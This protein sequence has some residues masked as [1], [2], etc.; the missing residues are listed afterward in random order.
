MFLDLVNPAFGLVFWQTVTFLTILFILSKFAWKPIM[1]GL[2]EREQNIEDA[3]STAKKAREEMAEMKSENEKLLAQ[4]RVERDKMLKEAQVASNNM[5]TEA[6]DKA[7]AEGARLLESARI[8]I[9]NEK[10]AAITEVKNQAATLSIHIAEKL[11]KRELANE[12]AQKQLVDEFIKEAK[13][14]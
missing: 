13:F 2:K 9:N 6:K 1:S 3:L 11:L 8:S 14:N 12:Q 5:I 7:S 4:A 10:Q